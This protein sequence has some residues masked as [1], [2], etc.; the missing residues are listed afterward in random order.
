MKT[1]ATLL[2]DVKTLPSLPAIAV[3]II[4]EVKKDKSSITELAAIISYDP[5]LSAKILK[6]ANSS[7]YALPY[8]VESIERAVNV[9]GLEALKNIAL[10]FVIVKGL[11]KNSVDRFDHE[12]FWKRSITAAVC[13]EM[14]SARMG[15]Q[16]ED[17]F[18]TPLLMDMG[19]IIMYMSQPDEYLKVFDE[20]KTAKMALDEAER[21]VF[22]FDHQEVGSAMLK[23]WGLSEDIH[24]PIAYHHKTGECPPDH[25][26]MAE[27]LKMSDIASSV[28]HSD[29]ST[30]KLMEIQELLQKKLDISEEEAGTFI[31]EVAEKTI[32]IL[33]TF[34]IDAGDMKPYSQIL[35]E[36]NE[37]LG[38]LNLSYEQLVMELKKEKDKVDAMATELKSA[39]EKLRGLAFQDGLTGLYNRRYFEEQLEKELDRVNRYSRIL[40]LIM[41]DID[42]F[43]NINDTYGHPQGDIILSTVA[44]VFNKS[45]RHPDTAARYGGEE[46]VVILPETNVQGA[47]VLAERLREAVEKL[48]INADTKI[49]K[50]TISL[51]VTEYKAE[52][53]RKSPT[54]VIDTADKALYHSKETGRNKLSIVL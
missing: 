43:K 42:H 26:D 10:S 3:R 20:K 8:K 24:V 46:F 4:Q 37:E 22:G 38:K 27:V 52:K 9:L 31:D 30:E 36:A 13:S 29:K 15:M 6:I 32:E 25:R 18:V 2:K 23:E 45:I 34:E 47:V 33:A 40:S 28:Y 50:I 1:L 19:L 44:D 12:F 53:G 49:I 54:E 16:R 5:A 48:E 14:L 35:Q 51:G 11:K 21:K 39:N 7:F 41:I 17:T